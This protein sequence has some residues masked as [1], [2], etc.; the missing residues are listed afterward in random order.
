MLLSSMLASGKR[1]PG[2]RALLYIYIRAID[3]DEKEGNSVRPG[4]T[5]GPA[6]LRGASFF[7][8]WKEE[9]GEEAV[10]RQEDRIDFACES[11][12]FWS[13]FANINLDVEES[14]VKA[15]PPL[16]KKRDEAEKRMAYKYPRAQNISLW[17][18]DL[19]RW[20]GAGVF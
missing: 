13:Y 9:S 15:P 6:T 10:A 4:A 16:K 8:S 1:S 20:G 3:Y 17:T 11:I 7:L 2:P 18:C 14:M 12:D 19:L 5:W